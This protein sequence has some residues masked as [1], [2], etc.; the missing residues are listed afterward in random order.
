MHIEQL[1]FYSKKDE[2]GALTSYLNW[3]C[4]IEI[5]L[6]RTHQAKLADR[7]YHQILR[8]STMRK[9]LRWLLYGHRR[10]R[11]PFTLR[12]HPK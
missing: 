5:Y 1:T 9:N 3:L 11:D 6:R 4:E 8:V 12:I 7:F 10:D 2:I